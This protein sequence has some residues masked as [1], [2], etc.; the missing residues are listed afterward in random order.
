MYCLITE[1]LYIIFN[2]SW[3]YTKDIGVHVVEDLSS[4]EDHLRAEFPVDKSYCLVVFKSKVQALAFYFSEVQSHPA[5]SG[6]GSPRELTYQ[7]VQLI[8]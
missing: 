2:F 4:R 5:L 8:S 3:F 6:L 1:L 7:E